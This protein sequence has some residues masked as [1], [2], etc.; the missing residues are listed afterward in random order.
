MKKYHVKN[1]I[2]FIKAPYQIIGDQNEKYF[3]HLRPV[4][5]ADFNALVFIS[6]EKKNKQDLALQTKASIVICDHSICISTE[7]A[8]RKCFVVVDNP[9]LVF[10]MVGSNLFG[11]QV[12]FGVHPTACIHPEAKVHSKTYIGPF[13]YIG[14]SEIDE[15]VIIFGNCHIYDGVRIGKNVIINAGCVIGSSGFGYLRDENG[16]S[17]NFPHVGGVII[18]NNVEIGANSCI[19][20]GALSD[21]VLKEGAKIDNLVHIAHNVIVG[22]HSYVI[23]QAMVGGSTILGDFS[24]IAPSAVLRDQ[25]KIGNKAIIG[26]GAVVTKNVPENEIWAGSPA[27]P[28][29][30]FLSLQE[31]IKNFPTT[32]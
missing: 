1:I 25:I 13:T 26:L 15:G 5:E 14:K 8:A 16:I 9:K 28:L 21:T 10:A 19:D 27:R 3:T 12:K 17:I 2:S 6:P 23:A 31:K 4:H 7:M 30:E 22:K 24:W 11:P 32:P 18:E 20:R 29:K